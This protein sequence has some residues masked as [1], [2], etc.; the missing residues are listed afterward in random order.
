MTTVLEV[1]KAGPVIPVLAFKSADEAV[2]VCR[3]LYEAGIRVFEIT[4]RHATALEAIKAV[5]DDL[6]EDAIV[7][8]GTV[9]TPELAEK[10]KAAGAVFG[11]SPGLTEELAKAVKALDWAFLP[12]VASI[13]EAM[14][15]KE[16]GFTEL[17]FFPAS[18][19]G[20]PAFLKAVGSVLP[21]LTFC[22][23]GGVTP[24]TADDY[25]VLANVATVGGSWITP[26]GEG[27]TIDLVK[28]KELAAAA[29]AA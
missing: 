28:V 23:T 25:R 13:S 19:S 17:K 20:G 15:A 22:P 9:L 21:D 3:A 16:W 14:Q 12:G 4:L 2:A 18:V 26:R 8:A 11:V 6:P 7:G 1:M 10:A 5:A 27:G 29:I 24:S